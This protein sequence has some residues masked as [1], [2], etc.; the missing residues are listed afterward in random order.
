MLT[1][2]SRNWW[3]VVLRG[4]LAVLFGVMALLWPGLTLEVLVLFFGAYMLVD[5]V[6]A[7]VAAFT[8]RTGH[9]TW[10]V[11]L[12]EGLVG[13]AAG[14]VT[15]VVPGLATL[16]L[17]YVIA[18]WAIVTGVLEIAAAIR[19]RKEIRGE[20]LLA[21]SG[22]AS[23]VLGVLLL[24][25][26]AAGGLTVAWIIG[27]YAI[28]FGGMLLGLGLRLRKHGMQ[29]RGASQGGNIRPSSPPPVV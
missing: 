29:D 1:Q 3:A 13:I 15:F 27:F 9:D 22:I 8:N 2:L 26:P 5:G 18:F 16:A 14:I 23:I 21:L 28:L 10:W 11:L 19:L 20:L 17:I 12:L 6:F 25:F 4:V 7:I 24:A